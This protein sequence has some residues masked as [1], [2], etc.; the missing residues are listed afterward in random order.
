MA[1]SAA[2]SFGKPRRRAIAYSATRGADTHA[3]AQE[4]AYYD[5]LF[6]VVDKDDVSD[7][8]TRHAQ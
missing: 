4:R 6:N 3:D 7:C 1:S 8:A 5:R 2:S